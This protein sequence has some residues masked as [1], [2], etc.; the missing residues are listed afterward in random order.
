MRNPYQSRRTQNSSVA[1]LDT[2][3]ERYRYFIK[4]IVATKK[5]WGL[6]H[7]GWAIGATS[8]GRNALPLWADKSYAK[9]CQTQTWLK[10]QPTA[11][12]LENFIFKMLPYAANE[13]VLLSI[14][15]TPEGQSVFLEPDKVLLDLK[16]F[17]YEVFTKAPHFFEQN[18]DVPLPRNIRINNM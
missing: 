13:K 14:M 1:N 3:L 8:Q 9:L 17:L 6:Y 10:Y 7:E 12:S 16:S 18:L 5:V 4:N 15:M 11:I 2:S